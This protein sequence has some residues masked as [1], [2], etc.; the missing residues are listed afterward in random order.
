MN[1]MRNPASVRL[2][3]AILRGRLTSVVER[4]DY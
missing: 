4:V 2:H 3:L 1:S